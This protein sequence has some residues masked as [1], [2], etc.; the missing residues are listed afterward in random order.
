MSSLFLWLS[1]RFRGRGVCK[2]CVLPII[3]CARLRCSARSGGV[4]SLGPHCGTRVVFGRLCFLIAYTV[5]QSG[6]IFRLVTFAVMQRSLVER[7]PYVRCFSVA[8]SC[9]FFI[10]VCVFNTVVGIYGHVCS[11]TGC[12]IM[13][14]VLG[15]SQLFFKRM[16]VL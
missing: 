16:K 12:I 7:C 15:H 4:C 13:M 11:A 10:L 6:F 2:P 3:E 5:V 14:R 8:A 1:T 9:I